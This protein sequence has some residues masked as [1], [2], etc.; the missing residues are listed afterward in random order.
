MI[1]HFKILHPDLLLILDTIL[2]SKRKPSVFYD[3]KED[4]ANAGCHSFMK[5]VHAGGILDEICWSILKKSFTIQAMNCFVFHA[6]LVYRFTSKIPALGF[7]QYIFSLSLS[8]SLSLS[9]RTKQIHYGGNKIN[10]DIL[11]N[12]VT[13]CF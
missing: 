3:R 7:A 11:T 5:V 12:E 4:P 13:P 2:H 1:S 6:L 10:W 9:F 8:L